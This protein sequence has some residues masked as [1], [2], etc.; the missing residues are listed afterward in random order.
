MTNDIDADVENYFG[1]IESSKSKRTLIDPLDDTAMIQAIKDFAVRRDVT[2]MIAPN[3]KLSGYD[4][5]DAD[6]NKIV[7][8]KFWELI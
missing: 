1:E 4:I 3:N 5:F 7:N 2:I 8:D 6:I